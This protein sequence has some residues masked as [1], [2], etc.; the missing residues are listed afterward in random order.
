MAD[1]RASHLVRSTGIRWTER[2]TGC[3]CCHFISRQIF[4]R[5]LADGVHSALTFAWPVFYLS[6]N[7]LTRMPDEMFTL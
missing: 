6:L 2:E 5:S 3:R 4:Q 1:A 7:E